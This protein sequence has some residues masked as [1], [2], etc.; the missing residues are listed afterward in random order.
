MAKRHKISTTI[1][2]ESAAYLRRL[3]DAGKAPNLAGA[4]DLAVARLRRAERRARL[5]K[6]TAAYF[7]GLSQEG[8]AEEAVLQHALDQ[9]ADEVDFERS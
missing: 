3:V 1:S 7:E 9:S 6:A 2:V 5:E 8:A 4:L